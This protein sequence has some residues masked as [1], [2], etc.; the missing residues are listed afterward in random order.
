MKPLDPTTVPASHRS[1]RGRSG[2]VHG[3][4]PILPRAYIRADARKTRK[5]RKGA[6]A[7]ATMKRILLKRLG[8]R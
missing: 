6:K 8:I 7:R 2:L 5:G 3:P 4:A 1:K